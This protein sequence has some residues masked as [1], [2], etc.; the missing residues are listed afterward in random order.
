VMASP[1]SELEQ[2]RQKLVQ[3]RDR[4]H[5]QRVALPDGGMVMVKPRSR[6]LRARGMRGPHQSAPCQTH[7]VNC[8]LVLVDDSHVWQHCHVRRLK[9]C[10]QVA[11]V[12]VVDGESTLST[13]PLAP[14]VPHVYPDAG[15]FVS[16]DDSVSSG[17][18]GPPVLISSSDGESDEDGDGGLLALVSSD[19]ED[20]GVGG[21][22]GASPV[23]QACSPAPTDNGVFYGGEEA[24]E[25]WS[26]VSAS[27]VASDKIP[28]TREEVDV[29]LHEGATPVYRRPYP[30]PFHLREEEGPS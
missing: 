19:D 11:G 4:E 27:E 15:G 23:V 7:G 24:L 2:L 30:T 14:P 20:L 28:A 18:G 12:V 17:D 25:Y 1:R 29:P 5:R 8:R 21:D 22:G 13:G 16:G 26:A 9:E 6:R 10:A 3:G